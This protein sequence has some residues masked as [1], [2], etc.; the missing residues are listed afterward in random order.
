MSE[1]A[2]LAPEVQPEPEQSYE[3]FVKTRFTEEP[4][5]E[6]SETAPIEEPVKTE[7]ES[8]TGNKQES[9][10][11]A[12]DT[13]KDKKKGGFQR[14]IDRLYAEK[15]AEQQ[16]ALAAEEKAKALEARLA[17]L[18]AAGIKRS[19]ARTDFASRGADHSG[20]P[21]EPHYEDYKTLDDY[22]AAKRQWKSDDDAWLLKEVKRQLKEEEKADREKSERQKR[23]LTVQ[24]RFQTAAAKYEDFDDVV[25]GWRFPIPEGMGS[26]LQDSDLEADILYFLAKN[27][28]DA[29][30]IAGLSPIAQIREIGKIEDRLSQSPPKAEESNSITPETR[31]PP[32][33][34]KAPAPISP[35]QSRAQT[36]EKSPNEET[37]AE[38]EKRRKRELGLK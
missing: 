21:E 14:R 25:G 26:A 16:K 29:I 32:A 24:A 36:A 2:V 19:D 13:P 20:R 30:R 4:K 38:F 9:E 15:Y 10:E 31:K 11:P 3:D 23:E 35:V 7:P 1:N 28:V 8:E 22:Y 17:A 27:P 18:E 12:K 5:E 6:P 37:Y 33:A 34:S